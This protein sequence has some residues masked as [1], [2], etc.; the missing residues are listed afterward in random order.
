MPLNFINTN[1]RNDCKIDNDILELYFF[2]NGRKLI[3]VRI[4]SI[5]WIYN[6]VID[7]WQLLEKFKRIVF[8]GLNIKSAVFLV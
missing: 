7:Q 5:N 1:Y 3:I 2:L 8:I 6:H 4:I